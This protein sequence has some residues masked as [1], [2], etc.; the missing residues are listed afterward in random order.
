VRKLGA[1]ELSVKA[2]KLR[3]MA[4]DMIDKAG[5]GHIGGSFSAMDILTALYFN[6]LDIDPRDPN[7]RDRDRFILSAG[8]KAAAY[9]PV[10]AERGYFAVELLDTFNQLDSP[11]AMHPDMNKIPGCDM[12]TGSLGHGLPV[13]AGMALALRMDNLSSRVFVLMGDGEIHEGT[14]WEAAMG[15]AH[16]GLE[17]LIAIVDYNKCTMDGPIDSVMPLEPI[18]EKW[19]SFGWG[20]RRIDG[21]DM[22][23]ILEAFSRLPEL[24][25]RPTVVIADTVKGKG[26]PSIEGDYHWHYGRLSDMQR[27]EAEATLRR[28]M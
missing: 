21:N 24:D 6:V 28:G 3:M 18:E 9:V 26:V 15:A 2:S 23:Q 8:H 13:A 11:F 4:I 14:V 27:R 17:N 1:Q 12:S 20:V 16:F 5:G 10:L 22:Q 25:G 19:R 7:K